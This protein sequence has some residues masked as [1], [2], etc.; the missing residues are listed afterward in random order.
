MTGLIEYPGSGYCLECRCVFPVR[1]MVGTYCETCNDRRAARIKRELEMSEN[2][3]KRK[4]AKTLLERIQELG[5]DRQSLSSMLDEFTEM[6]GGSKGLAK[7]IHQDFHLARGTWEGEKPEGYIHEH[8]NN[9]VANYWKVILGIMDRNEERHK[10]D[11]S[12]LTEEELQATV[13]GVAIEQVKTDPDFRNLVVAAMMQSM[14]I[15]GFKQ[16]ASGNQAL[17]PLEPEPDYGDEHEED[18]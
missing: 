12:G 14:G 1:N 4:T 18:D 9:T 11:L 17:P 3:V 16:A 2:R 15:E 6:N 10:M 7:L 13:L 8:S 5:S